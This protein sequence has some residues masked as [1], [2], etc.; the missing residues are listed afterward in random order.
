MNN[1]IDAE[2]YLKVI[3]DESQKPR[4]YRV[5]EDATH[6]ARGYNRICGDALTIFL[7]VEGDHI[8][9]ASFIGDCCAVCK[10]SASKLTTRLK[11]MTTRKFEQLRENF[12]NLL[13]GVAI[14]DE[15]IAMLGDLYILRN[16]CEYPSR[17]P[18][19]NL[20]WSTVHAALTGQPETSTE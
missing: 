10:C 17:I 15:A 12:E 20:A 4:N 8:A 19:A 3:V 13:S 11:S 18:C 5:I 16:V 9:D 7:S 1:H 6:Q 2:L 14:S